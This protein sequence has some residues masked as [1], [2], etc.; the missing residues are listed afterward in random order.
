MQKGS[1]Y[2]MD[3]PDGDVEKIDLI[4]RDDVYSWHKEDMY[5]LFDQ[6][7]HPGQNGAIVPSLAFDLYN[8]NPLQDLFVL[9]DVRAEIRRDFLYDVK[10]IMSIAKIREPGKIDLLLVQ[11]QTD[12]PLG[13]GNL[14]KAE[15]SLHG[16]YETDYHRNLD[17]SYQATKEVA[18]ALK[19]TGLYTAE[20]I[21][22]RSGRPLKEDLE[23]LIRFEFQETP[24]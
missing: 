11:E 9:S 15:N 17:G 19:N 20:Q 12:K 24:I 3:N 14:L 1:Y 21:R 10:P 22:F 18:E 2:S 16:F 23:K 13:Y 5:T 8:G 7:Y 4:G 6:H